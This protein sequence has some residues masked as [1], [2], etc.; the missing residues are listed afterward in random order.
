M[1]GPSRQ[2]TSSVAVTIAASCVLWLVG[3]PASAAPGDTQLV[4]TTAA[5]AGAD[6][7]TTGISPDGRFVLFTTTSTDVVAG[8][9]SFGVVLK[10]RSLGT[11]R[12]VTTFGV[13]GATV[14]ADGRFVAFATFEAVLPSDTNG[15]QDVYVRDMQTMGV[16]R[17]TVGV[18]GAQPNNSSDGAVISA[19]GRFVVFRSEA[20]NLVTGDT[21]GV[22]DVFVRDLQ[23]G[24]TERVSVTS[25]E[26]AIDGL[27]WSPSISG[28]GRYV[29]FQ[30]TAALVPG[31]TNGH[32]DVY[33]R[34]RT[35]GTTERISVSSTGSQGNRESY[36]PS[37]QVGVMS[38]DGRFVAFLSGADNLVP[39]DTN[40][41]W[42]VFVRD[43]QL[44]LTERISV[45]SS[46][47]Q[48]T[49]MSFGGPVSSDGRYVAFIS[50]A[51]NLVAG[52]L[53]GQDDVFVRD[54]E[55]G[56]TTR[57]NVSSLGVQSNGETFEPV[58]LTADGTTVFFN[59]TGTN[60]V[61]IA[62]PPSASKVYLHELGDSH[63]GGG[64]VL[65]PS[66]LGFGDATIQ[67]ATSRNI[68]F[69]NTDDQSIAGPSLSIAG[70]NAAA[71]TARH[72]CG[73]TV[74]AGGACSI[75]VTFRPF[76]VGAKTAQLAVTAGTETQTVALTGRGVLAQ[77][78]LTPTAIAFGVHA[79][80]TSTQRSV[81]VRNTGPGVM[82]VRWIGI[83]GTNADQ[84]DSRRWCP[85]M[86]EPGHVCN[87]PVIFAPTT[88]GSKTATLVVSP[89]ASG[90]PGRVSLTGSATD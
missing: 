58:F 9:N 49:A 78:T 33:L 32:A 28:D 62:T 79:I 12:Q 2:R 90:N 20:N 69:T 84:F 37:G 24:T 25:N 17:A 19:N 44:G 14:S 41:V 29:V 73:A 54:R 27:S 13:D 10:D 15:T 6:G 7:Y 23:S 72:D 52:D 43:R 39:G 71:F 51:P 8:G 68:I 42:D 82:P 59:N 83:Q 16:V 85:G 80:G 88:V 36:V 5:G 31:D 57:V 56:T 30:S 3:P 77:F 46:E 26:I 38:P 40:A 66:V 35:A 11:S 18:G 61:P 64:F 81:Q 4:S 1:T 22:W 34:D 87:I 21:T 65:E 63:T 47:A 74:A 55:L 50:S 53:N 70:S 45:S 86:L 75:I 60:L 67:V 76:S 89:G 48:A